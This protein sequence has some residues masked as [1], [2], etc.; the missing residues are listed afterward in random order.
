MHLNS[1]NFA[2]HNDMLLKQEQKEN[3]PILRCTC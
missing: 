2:V 3:I 1:G